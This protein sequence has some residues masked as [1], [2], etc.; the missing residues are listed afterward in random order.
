MNLNKHQRNTLSKAPRWVHTYTWSIFGVLFLILLVFFILYKDTDIWYLWFGNE[1]KDRGA[2]AEAI[3]PGIFRTQAN[4]W[5]NLFYIFVGLYIVVY[6]WWDVRRTTSD[7]DPYAVRQPA[8]MALY[9]LACVV[10]GFGSGLM[11]ASMMPFGHKADVFGMYFTFVALIALQW[12]RW[13][14][15]VPFTNRRWPSWPVLG[16]LAI[17]VSLFLLIYGKAFG[18]ASNILGRLTLL[19]GLGIVLDLIWR[20]NAQQY[21]WLLLAFISLLVGGYLQ[22]QD[23]AR[24]FDPSDA[25]L[26]GHAVWHLLTA[27]MYAFMGIFYRTEIPRLKRTGFGKSIRT[28]NNKEG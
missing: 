20:K 11:H 10:L 12:G 23:V 8:L 25:W 9:G 26:Q 16:T 28:E 24:R 18:G 6:A 2:F 22:R 4:T 7:S 3:T 5:S 27:A 21:I 15:Y 1:P 17:A 14:P 19:I 13:I